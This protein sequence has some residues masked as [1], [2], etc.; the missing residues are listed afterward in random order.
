MNGDKSILSIL[1]DNEPGVLSRITG[2][3][4]GRGYNIE[5]LS[6]A[7]TMDPAISRITMITRGDKP[8][9][10]QIKKQLNKLINVIK[11][12]DLTDQRH[13]L[14]ELALIKVYAKAENRAEILRIVDI[15]RCKI[16]DSG[17][18]HYTLEVAADEDKLSALLNLLQP[19]GIKEIARTGSIALLR[20]LQ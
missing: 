9:V 11:V 18:E 7:E 10:E 6:V 3:F 15:F 17:P 16:V 2:L 4:S 20:E 13:V 19:M 1:V 12:L 5:S 14:R 8:I